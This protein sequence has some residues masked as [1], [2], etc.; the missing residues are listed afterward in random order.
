MSR[1]AV[2]VGPVLYSLG[3]G[4]GL[5]ADTVVPEPALPF[6]DALQFSLTGS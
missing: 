5:L 1:I 3:L 2:T 4:L 6:V